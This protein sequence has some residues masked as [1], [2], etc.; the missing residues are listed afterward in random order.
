MPR[1]SAE[2]AGVAAGN[3]RIDGREQARREPVFKRAW[4]AGPVDIVRFLGEL[5]R[6]FPEGGEEAVGEARGRQAERR[7]WEYSG[8]CRVPRSVNE[9]GPWVRMAQ[10]SCRTLC[11]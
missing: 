3:R 5:A 8:I 4:M 2:R 9:R 11:P 7:R 6:D 10:R 1:E